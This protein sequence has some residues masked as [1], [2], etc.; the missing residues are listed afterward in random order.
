M[1]GLAP[2]AEH[3]RLV[4]QTER[5][6]I[7]FFVAKGPADSCGSGCSEWI[8]ASGIFDAGSADRFRDFIGKL[9][10][11]NLP[12]F[13]HS[14]GGSVKAAIEIGYILRARRM[15]AGVGRAD[16]KCRV[17]DKQAACQNLIKAGQ[18][19]DAKL[20]ANDAQCHSA[21][22]YAFA[23]AS[24][25]RVASKAVVGVHSGRLQKK[26]AR[27]PHTITLAVLEKV[28]RRYYQDMGIEP[29]LV[30]IEVRTP[31]ERI[32]VLNRGEIARFGLETRDDSYE[33]AWRSSDLI[34]GKF[35]VMKSITLRAAA[36]S[37]EY[38]TY[39]FQFACDAA[40]KTYLMY[41]RELALH[42]GRITKRVGLKFGSED[43]IF[44]SKQNDAGIE[45]GVSGVPG[46]VT[47][48]SDAKAM[49]LVEKRSVAAPG[50]WPGT[51]DLASELNFSTSGLAEGLAELRKRCNA[52]P[53]VP[54]GKP[55]I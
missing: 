50:P 22:V 49:T 20:I 36:E 2:P 41:Q 24:S 7:T 14:P 30:D 13:F 39:R 46:N 38:L 5:R 11:R 19:I 10:G 16:T 17:F 8:A 21:C 45:V 35:V 15:S 27:L 55:A 33:T 37:A 3:N 12:I 26:V 25:R 6:P 18:S 4:A 28:S 29:A 32:Y 31:H 43:F 51:V 9:N 34:D 1:A 42:T 48:L 47:K 23:G 54:A 53:A 52:A 44:V 40:G